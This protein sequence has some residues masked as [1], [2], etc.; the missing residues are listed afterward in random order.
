MDMRR[1]AAVSTNSSCLVGTEGFPS[2]V[3]QWCEGGSKVLH[4]MGTTYSTS[5]LAGRTPWTHR[6]EAAGRELPPHLIS[7]NVWRDFGAR[8][9]PFQGV[10]GCV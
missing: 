4:S 6:G 8:E 5:E 7:S 10:K 9:T 1:H 2:T 3:V